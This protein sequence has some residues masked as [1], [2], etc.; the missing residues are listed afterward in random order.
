[1]KYMVIINGKN[2]ISEKEASNLYN[3]SISW[4]QQRRYK[5]LPP[6]FIRL[7]GRGKVYYSTDELDLWF[8]QNLI[9]Y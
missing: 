8:R 1:M 7:E 9:E 5:K 2:Y 3:Y 4:F 6:H